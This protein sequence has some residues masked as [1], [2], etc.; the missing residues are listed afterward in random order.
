MFVYKRFL[1]FLQ[2][3]IYIGYKL[4]SKISISLIFQYL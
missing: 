3:S 4:I 2:R 1:K